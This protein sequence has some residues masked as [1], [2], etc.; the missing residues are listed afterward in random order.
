MAIVS[1]GYELNVTLVDSGLDTSTLRYDLRKTVYADALADAQ[2]IVARLSAITRAAVKGY[3]LVERF[4]EDSMS[5]PLGVNI[6]ERASIVLLIDGQ[7]G[8]TATVNIPAPL[9]GIFVSQSGAGANDVDPTNADLV[10]YISTWRAGASGLADISDG[11]AV[12]VTNNGI[13]RGRR[14]HRSSSYG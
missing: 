3:T 9:G 10:T 2:T 1:N 12:A 13:L 4:V 7:P 14:T 8:K 6:E 5:L 11:E